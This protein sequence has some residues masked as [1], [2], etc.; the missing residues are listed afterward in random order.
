MNRETRR[1]TDGAMMAAIIGVL[2][3]INRQTAGLIEVSFVW[4]LPLPM[5]FYAT[6]YG[7]KNSL[8]LFVAVILLTIVLGT[9]QTLFYIISEMLIGLVYG[10]GICDKTP[11]RKLVIRTIIMAVIADVLSMLVFASFFGYDLASEIGEYQAVVEKAFGS[12][13]MSVNDSSQL[14]QMLQTILIVSVVMSGVLEGYVTHLLSRLMLKRLRIYV[15]P[16]TP[17]YLYYPPKWSGYI[18]IACMLLTYVP[19]YIS[20]NNEIL[21]NLLLGLGFCG[22][23]YL[24]VFGM[25]AIAYYL[26]VEF[27]MKGLSGILAFVLG[28]VLSIVVAMLGFLYITTDIHDELLKGGNINASKNS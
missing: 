15:E 14:K 24:V 21:E 3:L 17:I 9:P 27:G 19:T 1:I 18:G 13:G 26:K 5:V 16:I 4:I 10:G 6:K 7:Y 2:L 22:Y 11:T 8:L 12:V 20:I 23:M 25:I 28:T